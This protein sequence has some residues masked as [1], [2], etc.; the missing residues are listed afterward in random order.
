MAVTCLQMCKFTASHSAVFGL[1]A[2]LLSRLCTACYMHERLDQNLWLVLKDNMCQHVCHSSERPALTSNDL[3][4]NCRCCCCCCYC[5]RLLLTEA[6]RN[7]KTHNKTTVAFM[8][9]IDKLIAWRA[10]SGGRASK[11]FRV[12]DALVEQL[13]HEDFRSSLE[14]DNYIS[15][16]HEALM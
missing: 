2:V 5:K 16:V 10:L 14:G 9:L 12:E 1:T 4:R 6:N 13:F 15:I 7:E 8:L 11:S 3:A